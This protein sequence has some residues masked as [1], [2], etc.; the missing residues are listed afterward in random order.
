MCLA[1]GAGKYITLEMYG[2]GMHHSQMYREGR[3]GKGLTDDDSSRL[4]RQRSS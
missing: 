3:G 1:M 4:G 2:S